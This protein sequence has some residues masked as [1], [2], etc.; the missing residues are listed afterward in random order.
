MEDNSPAKS[1]EMPV[2]PLQLSTLAERSNNSLPSIVEEDTKDVEMREGDSS[3]L[4]RAN[5]AEPPTP[6][7]ATKNAKRYT[8]TTLQVCFMLFTCAR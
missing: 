6:R 8:V 1:A 5:G 7:T 3:Q 4:N 2:V